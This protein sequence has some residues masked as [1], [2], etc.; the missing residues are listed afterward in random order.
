MRLSISFI[1]VMLLSNLG[2]GQ[3]LEDYYSIA[4]ENNPG[5]Q[6]KYIAFEAAMKRTSQVNSLPDPILSFG[7]FISP[8]ETRVGPQQARFSL[9]QMF[10]WF[11]SLS[12]RGD[13]AAF[14]AEAVYQEFLDSR[15]KL[16]FNVASAYYSLYELKGWIDLESENLEL[17]MAFER[18]CTSRLENGD[19]SLADV[20]RADIRLNDAKT[21][22]S[23]LNKS[24]WP[25]QVRFNR[26]LNQGDSTAINVVDDLSADENFLIERNDSLLASNPQINR[27]DRLISAAEAQ[28]LHAR[29][30][31]GAKS[32]NRIGLWH[33]WRKG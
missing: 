27:L 24:Y 15:N 6:A 23:I 7:Y 25:A 20:L 1:I 4:A 26:L 2:M 12:A 9:S 16:F 17:L 21:N 10:P 29:R 32:G 5:V 31:G 33:S 14:R 11:G 19:G 22:L 28:E 30:S 3:T 13:A 8:V 18:L